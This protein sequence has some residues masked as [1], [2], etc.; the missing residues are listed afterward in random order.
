MIKLSSIPQLY[1]N[2]R[3]G[4]EI[5]VI[6]RRYGL[7]DWLSQLRIDTVRDWLKDEAG[8]PLANY[9]RSARVRMAL[10]DLGPTFIKLGQVLSLR[11]E[12]VGSE[13]ATEL[14]QLHSHVPADPFDAVREIVESEL[15]Q[16]LER[17]FSDFEPQA[18]ASASIG[19]VHRARLLDGQPVVVK[20]QHVGIQQRIREDLEVLAGLAHLADRIPE[21]ASWNPP[22][23]VEELSRSLRRELSFSRE[24]QNLQLFHRLLKESHGVRIPLPYPEYSASRVLTMEELHGRPVGSQWAAVDQ[25][26][27]DRQEL[28]AR[29]AELYMEMVFVHGV[30]HADPH[31]GNCLVLPSGQLGLLDFGMVGRIDDRLREA[32]EDMLLAIAARDSVMLTS[33]IRRVGRVPP[34]LDQG[35]LSLDVAD[36]IANYGSVPLDQLELSRALNDVTDIL[37]RN[38]ISLP[39]PTAL[40]IKTLITLEGTLHQLA[41]KFA[42]LEIMQPFFVRTRL[43]RYSPRRQAQRMRRLVMELEHLVETAPSQFSNVMQL[44]QDGKLDVHLA[45][46]GL[47]PSVNRL[48]LGLLT[49]SLL[50]GSSVLLA[51]RVPPLLFAGGEAAGLKDLS[52]LGL[53]GYAISLLVA[54]R[55]IRAI[56]KS[57]HL[58]ATGDED[59]TA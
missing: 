47:G 34:R 36:L 6:L 26:A 57:G 46:K 41:P 24:L 35:A 23:L 58:D 11:P 25:V 52:L 45:H 44:L 38:Q 56:N 50:L 10:T 2:L 22:M 37:H 55:L 28:A 21:I 53:V 7:A 4:R 49:S 18:I 43:R 42:L 27:I 1:R 20:V 17:L 15:G 12:L 14:R 54:L 39:P 30:Y 40:L 29:A 51:Y 33:L 9:S 32:I 5:L 13:L 59:P 19:Q 48:V 16:P 3:R 31:P 8:V